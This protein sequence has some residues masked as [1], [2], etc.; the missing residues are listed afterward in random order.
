MADKTLGEVLHEAR[1]AGGQKRPRPWP[2]ESWADR[3]PRLRAL[4]EA[5]ASAVAAAVREHDAS[6]LDAMSDRARR[7]ADGYPEGSEARASLLGRAGAYAKAAG[8]VR[9]GEAPRGEDSEP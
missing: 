8:I 3:D 7:A 6:I 9:G 2:P 5:M 1:E 4:D